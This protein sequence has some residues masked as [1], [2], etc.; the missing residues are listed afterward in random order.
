MTWRRILITQAIVALA[1]L[2]ESVESPLLGTW[3]GHPSLQYAA[4]SASAFVLLA[5]TLY[6]DELV[7]HGV[8]AARVVYPLAVFLAFPL[9][10]VI[11]GAVEEIYYF[12][13]RLPRAAAEAHRWVFISTAEGIAVIC[14]FG[15][16][17]YMN[18][19]TA[20]R[21]LD[22]VQA[23]ELKRVQLEEQLIESRLA[24]AEA[25]VDPQMLFSDLAEIRDGFSRSL[26]DADA[27]LD[28]L[29]QHLRTALAR[30]V[31]IEDKDSN[32]T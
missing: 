21:M 11:T 10:F 4:M 7:N 1:V 13:L 14:A 28:A 20:E 30:T 15:M 19:R 26:P 31:A 27:K 18:R 24:M 12:V 5:M 2:V 3:M 6:T 9:I 32:R 16:V 8:W 23:A 22:R 29:V 25:Q 17:I